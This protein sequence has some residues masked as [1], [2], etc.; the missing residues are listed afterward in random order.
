MAERGVQQILSTKTTIE[1]DKIVK[2]NFDT[3]ENDQTGK[4]FRN[5]YLSKPTETWLRG[6]WTLISSPGGVPLVHVA[7]LPGQGRLFC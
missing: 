7:G 1:W 6:T 4:N 5:I 2:N 3:L